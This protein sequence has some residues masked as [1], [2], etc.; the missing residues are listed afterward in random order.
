MTMV[1]AAN[2]GLGAALLPRFL[3]SRE[4]EEGLLVEAVPARTMATGQYHLA[5]PPDRAS[6]PPLAAFRDWI[7]AEIEE[8][9]LRSAAASAN[10][11]A[12]P[13]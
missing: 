3:V 11:L 2:A 13:S 6:Y 9:R 5:Y 10:S 1:E 4:L 12:I 8:D 7:V